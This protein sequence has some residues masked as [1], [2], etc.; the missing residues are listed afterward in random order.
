MTLAPW[1]TARPIAHRGL[2]D[3]RAGIPENSLAAV[4]A[5]VDAGYAA[6]LDLRACK[7][8][9]VVFHDRRLERMT[10]HAGQVASLTAAELARI[11]LAKSAETIPTLGDVLN[12]VGGRV[13]LML[14]TKNEGRAGVPERRI[15]DTLAPYC[16]EVAV[17][18]F[19]PF[20]L[21]WFARHAATLPRGQ[22]GA[23]FTGSDLPSWRRFLQR[24]FLLNVLSRPHFLL[25]E[26]E[27][28]PHWAV[29]WQ[30]RR[31]ATVIAFTVRSQADAV[32]AR[33]YADNY[34]FETIRP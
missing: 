15:L 31:G 27:A 34:I 6:E 12:L 3:P 11:P 21:A 2:F 23:R 22:T 7:D 1:I 8:D 9:I 24:N 13:P 16:G 19:N 4:R 33:A 26:L 18:S 25:Y 10:G 14:E 5:A 20:S 28:L 30:R 17:V 32:K 29:S